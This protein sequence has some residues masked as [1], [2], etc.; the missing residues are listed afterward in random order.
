MS[1][2]ESVTASA[3][4]YVTRNVAGPLAVAAGL[5]API[6]TVGAALSMVYDGGAGAI[7]MLLP[8]A[9]VAAEFTEIPSVPD[10]FG[11]LGVTVTVYDGLVPLTTTPAPA[12][13]VP[14]GTMLPA[15]ISVVNDSSNSKPNSTLFA[16]VGLL[17]S[18]VMVPS[19]AVLSTTNAALGP[20]DGAG[21]IPAAVAVPAATEMLTVPSPLKLFSV[22]VRVVAPAPDTTGVSYATFPVVLTVMLA[23]PKVIVCALL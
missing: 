7:V 11:L 9:S 5:G 21:S 18:N 4:V 14:V 3:P 12:A 13:R 1:L 22:T 15:A 23:A 17:S 19:G 6:E 16:L 10:A 8:A 2:L 20:A